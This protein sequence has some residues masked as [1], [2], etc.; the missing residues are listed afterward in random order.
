MLGRA[1]ADQLA[2]LECLALNRLATLAAQAEFDL[3]RALGLL[4]QAQAAAVR[5]GEQIDRAETH[6]NFAQ[7]G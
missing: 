3:V 6:W 2:S 4:E 5:S 7:V 1:R